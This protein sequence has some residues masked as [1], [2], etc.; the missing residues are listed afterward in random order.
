MVYGWGNNNDSSIG[1][2]TGAAMKITAPEQIMT[3]AK[4]VI[5]IEKA[6]YAVKNDGSVYRWGMIRNNENAYSPSYD[7]LVE[8]VL[9]ESLS[10][11]KRIFTVAERNYAL[12]ESGILYAWGNNSY[13]SLGIGSGGGS[14]VLEP[15]EVNFPESVNI[16]QIHGTPDS[17]PQIFAEMHDGSLY[18]WGYNQ[19]NY[20]QSAGSLGIDSNEYIVSTPQ[21][22]LDAGEPIKDIQ[23][24]R[25]LKENGDLFLWGDNPNHIPPQCTPLPFRPV[26]GPTDGVLDLSL[27]KKVDTPQIV[28]SRDTGAFP[29]T[30]TGVIYPLENDM[31]QEI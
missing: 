4:Q 5:A 30:Q 18:G 31:V 11:I 14:Y 13:G 10:G 23:S 6:L 16:K 26:I 3:D 15:T 20:G 12:S 19:Q 7:T 1:L 24:F 8:P 22:V 21:K 27:G 9:M 17:Y 2:G 29:N 28:A 25:I